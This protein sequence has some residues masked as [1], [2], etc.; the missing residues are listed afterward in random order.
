MET[1]DKSDL[2][3]LLRDSLLVEQ[4]EDDEIIV[5]KKYILK[6]IFVYDKTSFNK[7]MDQ[8]RYYMVYELPH[9]IY[10][11]VKNKK[12]NLDNFKDFYYEELTM[13]KT[14]KY[15][16]L[17]NKAAQYGYI[18]LMKYLHEN[19]HHWDTT[20]CIS[21]AHGN[22]LECLKYLHENG[23]KWDESTCAAAAW[24]GNYDCLVYARENGCYW[25]QVTCHDATYGGHLKCL[26][27]AIENGCR[28]D[29]KSCLEMATSEN[30]KAIIEY[31]RSLE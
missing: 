29:K 23:C 22:Q 24:N 15:F 17:M 6:K 12:P 25:N 11:Y 2:L 18:G 28:F 16:S 9:V 3:P 10:K 14:T 20:T 27:Y 1:I 19:N 7:T 5:P 26:K 31:I 8:L 30:H 21:A 4:F 13:L